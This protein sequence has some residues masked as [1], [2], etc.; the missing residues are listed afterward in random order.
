[1]FNLL[2]TNQPIKKMRPH[3]YFYNNSTNKLANNYFLDDYSLRVKGD[4]MLNHSPYSHVAGIHY[5]LYTMNL[6]YFSGK[7]EMYLR[8]KMIPH[9]KIELIAKEFETILSHNTRSEQ[10]P[11]LYDCRP[12][13]N[14]SRR[15]LRD[16]TP[17]IKYLEQ[18]Y[19]NYPILPQCEVQR[20]FQYLF[21]DYADEYLW[22]HAMFM[23][24]EPSFDRQVMG[25]R[26]LYEFA[27]QSQLRFCYVPNLIKPHLL[28]LR[29][30]LFSSYGEDCTTK[31][32]KDV[33][34]NYYYRLLEV[35]EKILSQQP[36]L[37]GNK[38][39]LI[40]IAFMG[41][42][43]RHFSSDFTPRKIM[44]EVAPNVFEWIARMW[45]ARG[46]KY[47]HIPDNFPPAQKLHD[48]WKELLCLLKD[49]LRYM[50]LNANAYV[51]GKSCFKFEDGGETF[52][53][54]VVHYRAWCYSD[55]QKQYMLTSHESQIKIKEIFDQYDLTQYF[56]P[57]LKTKIEPECCTEPPFC[58]K[59]NYFDARLSHKW[60]FESIL[61]HWLITHPVT[62]I[63]MFGTVLGLVINKLNKT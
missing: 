35:L 43:F 40:D 49:Y 18:E 1:M 28:S 13:T 38:P 60:N 21:E 3:T 61:A 53:V 34:V 48:N 23:R 22:R 25:L 46:S 37:F 27:M 44:Q 20:F 33:I 30:W 54:P 7:I 36:Y 32:K 56:E 5:K 14:E 50:K 41:P 11:Q 6:S 15:W 16:T 39:S 24:W 47:E 52:V 26:F 59:P 17:M 12:T 29:Q 31:S 45:N 19:P 62:K 58:I 51:D 55:I 4:A 10:L 42:F 9:Q 2:L 63:V 8:Y 57:M